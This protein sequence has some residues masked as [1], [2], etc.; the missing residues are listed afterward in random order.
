MIATL[1]R[2]GKL[3]IGFDKVQKKNWEKRNP[4]LNTEYERGYI[5]KQ[6]LPK[7]AIL[8]DVAHEHA[9]YI[10]ACIEMEQNYEVIDPYHPDWVNLVKNSN[11]EVFLFWPT[12]YKPIQKQ[13]W[14]ERLFTIKHYLKKNVFPS[15]EVLWLYESKRKSLNW[16]ES[17][18][19]PHPKTTVFFDKQSALDFINNAELPLVCKTDQGA[20]STGVY[21]LK[22]KAQA[23]KVIKR[24]F[25]RGL[26]MK[27]KGW[28]DVHQGYIIFQEFLP[29]CNEWRM[30]RVGDSYFC[31][32]KIKVGEFHSGSG[33]I[34]WA[35][36]PEFLL[37]SIK[38]IS[39]KLDIPNINVDYFE[40]KDGRFLI[41]EVHAL[42]GGKEIHHPELEGRYLYLRE[43]G[44][45]FEK[46]DFF[47]NRCA[48]LRIEWIQKNL[49]SRY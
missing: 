22:T 38:E 26:R 23:V 12:I 45:V 9:L 18:N 34:E 41:N 4:Y 39:D 5:F 32:F 35:K 25:G 43:K 28:N 33:D 27:N 42:W 16:L 44:W 19:Y 14:D 10:K 8:S 40:T 15:F 17:N 30:I 13:F 37:D 29:D 36:P 21:I 49:L 20:S 1:R 2:Y 48:N 24:A 31:R 11:S 6:G 47:R 46:G 7:I 3:L